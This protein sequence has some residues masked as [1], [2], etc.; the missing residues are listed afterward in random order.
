MDDGV[1]KI[2]DG[3]LV[4]ALRARATRVHV[5]SLITSAVITAATLVAG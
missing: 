1:E 2:T 5:L 4:S 3:K